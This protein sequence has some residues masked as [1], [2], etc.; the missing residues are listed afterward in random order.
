MNLGKSLLGLALGA[1]VATGAASYASA[2]ETR[3]A[4]AK[5]SLIEGIQERGALRVGLSTFQPWAMR[6]KKGELI[7]FEIDVAKQ[8]AKDMGV[9]IEFFPT[10]WDGIIPALL[11]GKFDVIISGM[12]ITPQRNLKVN[13]T[14][15]YA[16]SGYQLLANKK[17]AGGLSR[18]EDFNR[19]D[20]TIAARRAST[21]AEAVKV[22]MPKA[23]KLYFDDNVTA[24]L[25]LVNGRVHAV[26]FSPPKGQLEM[27]KHPELLYVPFDDLLRPTSEAFV[28]RKGDPDAVNYFD[29][30]I[31]FQTN[32]GFL[33]DRHDYW[34]LN[35][36]WI[37]QIQ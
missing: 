17:I 13:F 15:A 12:S 16:H 30:W 37:D 7:G 14:R 10:A 21:G 2:Q 32:L 23:K 33:K 1:L 8:V 27:M 19:S 22:F 24:F 29:N 5:D 11:T 31:E 36:D 25:E 3:Q 35:T 20:F 28:L 4:L 9:K 6:D 34:F 26:S 18:P